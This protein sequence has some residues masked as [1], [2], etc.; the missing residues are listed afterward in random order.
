MLLK[1]PI[2][3]PYALHLAGVV[4]IMP[5]SLCVIGVLEPRIPGNNPFGLLGVGGTCFL[6]I[7]D[8]FYCLEHLHKVK[9]LPP[10]DGSFA[11]AFPHLKL[12]SFKLPSLD[13]LP[14]SQLKPSME[15]HA[16]R[17]LDRPQKAARTRVF[18]SG[19]SS[20]QLDILTLVLKL[21]R[22]WQFPG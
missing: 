12:P 3:F 5:L 20:K 10:R 15:P 8:W 11:P 13:N 4:Y 16:P 9:Q 14:D 7:T 1:I 17:N 21:E 18:S 2:M 6:Y 22:T 19:N